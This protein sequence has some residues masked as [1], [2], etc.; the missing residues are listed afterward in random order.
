M[1]RLNKRVWIM[2][3]LLLGYGAMLVFAPDIPR[4]A[5]RGALASAGVKTNP[6]HVAKE[7]QNEDWME[8]NSPK[9]VG[10]FVFEAANSEDPEVSYKMDE[11]TYKELRPWG[12]VARRFFDD[13]KR[14][15]DAVLIASDSK[16]SFHDPRVCFTAQKFE[17]LTEGQTIVKT[18]TRGEIPVTIAEMNGPQ[19]KAFTA[20]FYRGPSGFEGTTSNLKQS[21]FMYQCRTMESPQGVFYRFIPLNE[22]ATPDEL[23]K[24][25]GEFVDE[26]NKVSNGFF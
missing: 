17:I 15:F 14:G 1:E 24:F 4:N 23:L 3:V 6:V 11:G 22:D 26:A 2:A 20:F 25:I 12:I 21:M 9:K 8:R 13:K 19:G 10:E 18:K 16:D 7:S 5:V